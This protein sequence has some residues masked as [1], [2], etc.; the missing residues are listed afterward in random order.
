MPMLDTSPAVGK[1]APYR[2]FGVAEHVKGETTRGSL[3]P[4]EFHQV[5]PGEPADRS[6]DERRGERQDELPRLPHYPHEEPST[7]ARA[8]RL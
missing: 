2:G 8:L 3:I 5:E 7:G 1:E 4:F 6:R